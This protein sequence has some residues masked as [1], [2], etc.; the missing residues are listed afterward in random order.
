MHYFQQTFSYVLIVMIE[1][2]FDL[3][4]FGFEKL[5]RNIVVS[6]G[7]LPKTFVATS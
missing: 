3:N 7:N 2:F 6:S 5:D 1:L 4:S